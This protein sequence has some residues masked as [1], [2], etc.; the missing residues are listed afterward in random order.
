MFGKDLKKPLFGRGMTVM[1]VFILLAVLLGARLWYLQM[2]EADKYKTGAYE[3]YTTEISISPKRGTIFDRNMT[4]LA[5]SDTVETVFIS[6][7]EI[8]N[9]N[10]NKE[11]DKVVDI[12]AQK[13]KIADFLSETLEVD[14]AEILERMER[15][16]SKYQII[17]KK[18][19]RE[20]CDKIRVF[21]NENKIVGI[22]LEED[23]KRSYPYGGLASHI[24]GF[25]NSDN[26][27]VLGVESYY[28]NYLKGSSGKIVTAQNAKGKDMPYKY[29]SYV[30]AENGL[31]VVLTIDW[32]I[33][34]ILEKNLEIAL[35]DN[36]AQNRVFGIIM[37]VNTAEILAPPNPTMI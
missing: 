19:E 20:T 24:I 31:G 12:S 22:H 15:T 6:P 30:E 28:N 16:K 4:P 25:T 23:V 35:R 13:N 8:A 36:K 21:I 34:S 11:G 1:A 17:K 9:Q 26:A 7:Y 33:Q 18:V 14:R 10:E 5:V 37:D 2:V 3:Q 29:E 32:Q 27:G